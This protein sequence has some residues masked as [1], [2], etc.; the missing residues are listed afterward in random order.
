[1]P[2][3][4]TDTEWTTRCREAMARYSGPLLREVAS[5][6][7]RPR[8]NQPNEELLEKSIGM[9]ANPPVIDRRIRDL[10]PAP[11]KLI[12]L[13]G[14]SRQPR[15]RVG[16]LLTLLSAL[17]HDEGITP[18]EEALKS[19]LIYPFPSFHS[20]PLDDFTTWLGRSGSILAEIFAHPAVTMRARGLDLGLPDLGNPEHPQPDPTHAA[21]GLDW[22]LRLAAVWQ[23][24]LAA[25]VRHTQANT[26]FKKDLTRL[27]GDEVLSGGWSSEVNKAPDLG[28]LALQW[29]A[30]AELF[31]DSDNEL[32]A[33]PFPAAWE[34]G[35]TA[36]LGDLL[37]ALPRVE[38]W[39]PLAGYAPSE[40]GL[41]P[42]PTAGFLALL[43][44]A[45]NDSTTGIEPSAIAEWLWTH[46][47]TWAGCIPKDDTASKGQRWLVGWLSAIAYP[48]GLID[49]PPDG[50][51]PLRLSIIGRHLLGTAP[52]PPAQPAFQQTLLIQPNAEIVAFRQGLTPALIATL[53]RFA[54]WTG[55]G[56]ACT[57]ELSAD[58]I[59]RGLES[60]LTLPMIMQTLARH[61]SR[62]IPPAVADLL[63]R[64][65][66]KRERITVFTSAVLVEFAT[67]AELDVAVNRGIVSVR[68]GDRIGMTA[69]GSEPGLNQL[70]LIANRDYEAKPQQCIR[71]DDDG[72]TLNIDVATADLL[73]DSE[74]NRFSVPLPPEP[75]APRRCRLTGELLRRAA[76]A[77]PAG[78]IDAWFVNRTGQ[79]LSPAGQL[80]LMGP[81]APSPTAERLL[82]VRFPSPALADGA[83]QWPETR[84]YISE[85]LGPTVVAVA[86]ENLAG[87]RSV[88]L[89][90]GIAVQ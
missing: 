87:L 80:F 31:R 25:P 75:L 5:K 29:A 11:R 64:W 55:L 85:R 77:L 24:V 90:V 28:V 37:A 60:G 79:P 84:K 53:S 34:G 17:G 57:L 69:D 21:D 18:I 43:L 68:L 56:P 38:S 47:P 71:V 32:T 59:Y 33:A 78:E 74:L 65:A 7:V 13:I 19:G 46:H 81:H 58:Q 6:L 40:T 52:V 89:D 66:S 26:L 88:L 4:D 27:Q 22:P 20:E 39:D 23:Q 72:V 62:P 70:R 48:L 50:D 9:L 12:T 82:A 41:S 54:R 8:A 73:L 76:E 86:E 15:W 16:H 14:L 45:R 63:Q 61:A 49:S 30:A 35:L 1:M 10:P 3:I 2:P 42:V 83:M 36:V 67:A 44:L 51:R